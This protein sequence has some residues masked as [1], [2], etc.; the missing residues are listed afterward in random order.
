MTTN[1]LTITTGNNITVRNRTTSLA[2]TQSGNN[3][4]VF[5]SGLVADS[6][7]GEANTAS[8]VGS[9][10]VGVFKQKS[11]VDL[12]FRNINAGSSKVT[13]TSDTANSEIDIDIAPS[14]ISHTAIADIGTNT[15]TQI[16]THIANTSNPHSVTAAQVGAAT[17]STKLD[18]FATPDDNTDLNASSLRHGLLPKLSGSSANFLDGSGSWSTPSGSGNVSKVG[19]PADN[20]I[21]VWTGDGT[22]EGDSNLTWNGTSF[23]IATAKNFQIAGT[24][25]LADSAG[26]TT[27]SGIDAIDATTEATFEAALELESLQGP[28]GV[29][30]LNSGTNASASTFW[31]GNGS[32]ATPSGSGDVVK[33]GTPLNNQ[34]GVWTGD[35]TIEGDANLTWDGTSFNIATAKNFQIAGATILADA[36]GTTTL[37]NIDALDATTE[38]TIEAAIDTLANLTSVQG[39]TVTLTGALVRSG[40]HSLTITT[41]NTTSVTLPTSGTL[42]ANLVEDTSPDLGGN[43]TLGAYNILYTAA[44]VSDTTF[45]GRYVSMTAGENV[46]FGEL[47][48]V[49]SD[50]KLWKTDANS[51]STMP[52][53]FIAAATI[54]ADAAGNFIMPGSF[55]RN[56]AWTWT[57]GGAIYASG[58]AGAMTQTAPST[59]G[60]TVQKVGIATHADRMYFTG[61]TVTVVVA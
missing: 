46:V 28:L 25:V 7:V 33:V 21:G 19:T 43:L 53:L 59:S 39:H 52:G 60:D 45:S 5:A 29:T 58:T 30:H 47:C 16:D 8:N 18:D 36:A 24:T 3:L 9:G 54:S 14:N 34:I 61:E 42:M 4:T 27:L 41:S 56:D 15:H 50:G 26:T 10:G 22:I 35:G 32:W 55:I 57:V 31:C 20:Q 37:S 1:S 2:I 12:Q 44:P 11:G 40:A 6:G 13:V 48:Y 49:K 23:N 51:A 17:T 38:A